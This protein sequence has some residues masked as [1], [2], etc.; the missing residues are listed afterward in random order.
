[1]KS[2]FGARPDHYQRLNL[3]EGAIEL[4]ENG[5]RTDAGEGSFEWWYFDCHLDDGSKFTIEFHTKPPYLSPSQP[6]T[7]FVSLI[8]DRPDGTQ[9]QKTYIT[10]PDAFKASQERC[11]VVIGGNTFEGDL[12]THRIHVEIDELVMDVTLNAEVP[13]WR[14]ATGHMF[15]GDDE[16]YYLAWLPVV[17]RAAVAVTLT[18]DGNREQLQGTGY[19]DHNWGNIA[20]R[21]IIDHWYWGR[22]HVKDYTV[23]AVMLVSGEMYGKQE[24]PLFML[25]RSGEI[26]ASAMGV[27]H[28]ACTATEL[29][30]NEQTGVPVAN[31]LVYDIQQMDSRYTASFVR[32]KDVFMFDFGRAGAYHRFVGD[33]TLE[34]HVN[35][36]LIETVSEDARWELLYFG[37]RA[38]SPAKELSPHRQSAPILVH[39]V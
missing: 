10:T 16:Q 25:A 4:W 34:H 8:L 29:R 12:R 17:P 38:C 9:I 11:D 37:A 32:Q 1:M 14:P 5:L 26:L 20:L 6:L 35:G 33:V 30:L 7:P 28:I 21:K 31:H 39:Q 24:F 27:E 19:H 18:I 23:I 2:I 13:S 22:A 36:R 15:F 3:T